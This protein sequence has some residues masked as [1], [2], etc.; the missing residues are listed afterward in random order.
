TQ[1]LVDYPTWYGAFEKAMADPALRN[2]D[3]TIDEARAVAMADQ[4]VI[5]A[6]SGGQAKDLAQIQRGGPLL[7]LF[8]NFYSYFAATLQ[9]AVERTGQTN[10]KRPHEVLRLAGDYLLLMV[11]PVIGSVLI[12]ALMKGAPDDDEEWVEQIIEEQIGFLMGFFPLT[13]EMT[14][15]V[16]AATG[17]GGQFGYSGPAGLRFFSDL[18]RLG[19]QVGQG[20]FDMAA[21]KAANNTAGVLFHYPAG[22]VNR[23]VEGTAALLEGRTDNP[24]AVIAGP[25]PRN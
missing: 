4:A 14:S 15:A 20:E 22:Q 12:N 11:V 21:F 3:G 17:F 23:T 2:E 5:A 25:P 16:Q 8:T 6:Q 9:L 19:A 24:L 18:Y 10:F 13:R 1:A 7:K